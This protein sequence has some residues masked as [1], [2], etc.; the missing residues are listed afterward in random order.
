MDKFT[1]RLQISNFF[2]DDDYSVAWLTDERGLALFP[3]GTILRDSHHR[4]SP[5]C[6]EQNLNLRKNLSSGLVQ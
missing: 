3:A 1:R 6:H 4:E 5:T 2:D